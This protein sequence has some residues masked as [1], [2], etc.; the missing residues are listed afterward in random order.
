MV[1]LSAVMFPAIWASPEKPMSRKLIL[2]IISNG[3]RG[4]VCVDCVAAHEHV[5]KRATGARMCWKRMMIMCYVKRSE[6]V[7]N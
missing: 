1:A 5:E 2:E 3:E 6:I 7:G 4:T